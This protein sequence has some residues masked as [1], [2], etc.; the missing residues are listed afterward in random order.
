[1]KEKEKTAKWDLNNYPV[2]FGMVMK[3]NKKGSPVVRLAIAYTFFKYSV[4]FLYDSLLV[5]K[6][7]SSY[8]IFVTAKLSEAS[9]LQ[10][11]SCNKYW[12]DTVSI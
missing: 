3:F 11:L 5:T 6:Q 4:V 7:I 1:M 9:M 2:E 10:C 12:M 8:C